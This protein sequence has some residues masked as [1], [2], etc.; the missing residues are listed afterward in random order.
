MYDF[1]VLPALLWWLQ[2]DSILSRFSSSLASWLILSSIDDGLALGSME[3]ESHS[4]LIKLIQSTFI[5]HMHMHQHIFLWSHKHA[6][7]STDLSLS[8]KSYI[9]HHCCITVSAGRITGATGRI[10]QFLLVH[11]RQSLTAII[12]HTSTHTRVSTLTHGMH[13]DLLLNMAER[14]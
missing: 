13:W 3:T 8:I 5:I 2:M 4:I 11:H 6:P 14:W 7:D 10:Y 12:S 1:F 9:I